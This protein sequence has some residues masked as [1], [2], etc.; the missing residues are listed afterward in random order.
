MS[1]ANSNSCWRE[2]FQRQAPNTPGVAYQSTV[3][4]RRRSLPTASNRRNP[5]ARHPYR[6]W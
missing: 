1:S 4:R 6:G 5:S 2:H 3:C